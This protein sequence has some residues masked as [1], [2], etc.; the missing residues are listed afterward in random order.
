MHIDWEPLRAIIDGHQRFI[1][2]SHVRPDADALGSELG[3]AAL[4]ESLGKSVRIVNA[5]PTPR[6]LAF[7]D[8]ENRVLQYGVQITED[9]VI[10]TDVHI[11]VDTSA[12]GQLAEVGTAWK[13]SNAVKVVIDHHVS[14]DA[15]GAVEFKD[16]EAEATGAMIYRMAEALGY[17]VTAKVAIPLFC[18]LATDTGWYR[19]SSTTSQTLRIAAA[20]I[21]AG[22][23]P[24]L[25]YEQLYEQYSLGRVKLTGRV[26]S[27]VKLDCDGRVAY[28]YVRWDDYAETQTEPAE[29]EDLVNECMRI[30]GTE[31]AF[32]LIEQSNR[33]I[34]VSFRSRT[35][36]DVARVAEQFRGGGHK[37]AAGA[38]LPGPLA[39]AE[40]S[41]LNAMKTALG[42]C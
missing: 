5:S 34:K 7:L 36:L 14:S 10:A 15:L 17:P 37:Q 32:I 20:L 3:L 6:R 35:T 27:R 29:T 26:L 18:A 23:R 11:V 4:L 13:K 1:L 28:T 38:I 9:E 8:P 24:N 31:C 30:G 33:H 42:A 39:E 40:S 16:V 25:L 21:D 22:A 12:W 19:F 2:T 41:V